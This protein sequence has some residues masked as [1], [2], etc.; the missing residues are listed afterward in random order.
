MKCTN[1]GKEYSSRYEACPSCGFEADTL[2]IDPRDVSVVNEHSERTHRSFRDIGKNGLFGEIFGG[3]FG[4]FD[5]EDEEESAPDDF[6]VDVFGQDF[7]EI[8]P[9]DIVEEEKPDIYD[10]S[11]DTGKKRF[12]K[13]HR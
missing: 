5:D 13:K 3:L 4:V 1:C 12:G 6:P 10:N 9:S 2:E 11:E 7:V 8:D